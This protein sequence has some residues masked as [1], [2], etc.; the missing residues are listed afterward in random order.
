MATRTGYAA[1]EAHE[2]YANVEDELSERDITE[3]FLND[4]PDQAT[5]LVA[6]LDVLHQVIGEVQTEA[7]AFAEDTVKEDEDEDDEDD[8][9]ED[10]D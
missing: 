4:N 9:D 7:E 1:L 5:K 8:E 3:E 10:E 6:A 2:L